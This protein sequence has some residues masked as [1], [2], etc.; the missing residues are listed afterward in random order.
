MVITVRLDP[1][2]RRQLDKLTRAHRVPRSEVVRRAIQ[3]MAKEDPATEEI[4]VY[5]RMKDHIGKVRSGRSDLSENTGEKFY[6]IV[7][8]KHRRRQKK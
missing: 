2:T 6:Q 8:E 5:E 4:N 3:R 1:E 7:L